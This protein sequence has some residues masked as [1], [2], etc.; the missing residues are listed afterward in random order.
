MSNLH[1]PFEPVA[2]ED[3]V[4]QIHKELRD[5]TEDIEYKDA[6]EGLSITITDSP[7]IILPISTPS[8]SI[9]VNNVHYERITNEKDSNRRILLALMQG[10]DALF[11][12]CEGNSIDWKIVLNQVELA[13]IRTEIL[14]QNDGQLA[15][16][17]AQLSNEQL[18]HIILLKDAFNPN[19]ND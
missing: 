13:Y 19:T 2:H 11:I 14:V 4:R 1:Y 10:A 15:D 5:Q 7:K 12:R 16:L 17:N 18:N 3:W 8:D 6:I 9:H